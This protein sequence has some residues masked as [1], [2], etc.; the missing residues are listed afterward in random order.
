MQ[1]PAAQTSLE[2]HPHRADRAR[3][4]AV[5]EPNAGSVGSRFA[6]EPHRVQRLED[7]T[8]QTPTLKYNKLPILCVLSEPALLPICASLP[9][10]QR[11]SC[12]PRHPIMVISRSST[13]ECRARLRFIAASL[14]SRLLVAFRGP[15]LPSSA[16]LH[17]P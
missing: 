10:P 2:P 5:R 17:C 7:L 14:G 3:P 16:R 6:S 8:P 9:S 4:R 1:L 15:S 11:V 12:A 13:R